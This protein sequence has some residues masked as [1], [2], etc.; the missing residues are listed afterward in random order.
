MGFNI[1]N[2]HQKSMLKGNKV[3][4]EKLSGRPDL[5]VGQQDLHIAGPQLILDLSQVQTLDGNLS[6]GGQHIHVY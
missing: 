3:E 4:V 2:A 5:P 1:A 6:D